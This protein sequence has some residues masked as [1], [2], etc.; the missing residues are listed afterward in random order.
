MRPGDLAE[1]LAEPPLGVGRCRR[2]TA[3]R[4]AVLPGDA[5][6]AALG[7]PEALLQVDHGPAAALRGQKFPRP[8]P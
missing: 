3:L 1:L 4:A 8:A 2:W 7:D 6:R 5:A